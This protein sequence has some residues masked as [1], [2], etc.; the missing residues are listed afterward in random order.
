M[1]H[2]WLMQKATGRLHAMKVLCHRHTHTHSIQASQ[3]NVCRCPVYLQ[4]WP[5]LAKSFGDPS[6]KVSFGSKKLLHIH[7]CRCH[8]S[9]GSPLLVGG[10]GVWK[11]YVKSKCTIQKIHSL[12]FELPTGN[13]HIAVHRPDRAILPAKLTEDVKYTKTFISRRQWK[14]HT[15]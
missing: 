11:K 15:S 1:V 9:E 13:I 10:E 3:K 8:H 14:K 7:H 4:C 5:Q 6:A 2:L 12:G